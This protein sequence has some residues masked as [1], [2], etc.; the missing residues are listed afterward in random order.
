MVM[1]QTT[2]GI[3]NASL[4]SLIQPHSLLAWQRVRVANMAATS[5]PEWAEMYKRYNSGI[6]HDCTQF[7][8]GVLGHNNPKELIIYIKKSSCL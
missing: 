2:N 5:G 3:F 4:F 8:V 6:D 7:A 1:L